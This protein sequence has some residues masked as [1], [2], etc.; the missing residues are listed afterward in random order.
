MSVLNNVP[1]LTSYGHGVAHRFR[2]DHE[3]LKKDWN[4]LS[5]K[6]MVRYL[7]RINSKPSRGNPQFEEKQKRL[8]NGQFPNA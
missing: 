5:V 6:Q 3:L 4:E 8:D 7:E 2:G 1:T